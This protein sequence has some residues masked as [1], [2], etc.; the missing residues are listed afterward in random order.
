MDESMDVSV[1]NV[2]EGQMNDGTF[3]RQK[4]AFK[5]DVKKVGKLGPV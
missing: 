5:R 1:T 2:P 3:M 4:Q